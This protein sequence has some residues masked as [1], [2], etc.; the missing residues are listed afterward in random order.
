MRKKYDNETLEKVF[1]YYSL[2][3]NRMLTAAQAADCLNLSESSLF[4]VIA[5]FKKNISKQR[6]EELIQKLKEE[7]TMEAQ[8]D[9]ISE[10]LKAK[11]LCPVI[12]E[13]APKGGGKIEVEK[14]TKIQPALSLHCTFHA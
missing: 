3:E 4:R 9:V 13:N 14:D 6:E 11:F 12:L 1:Y 8:S 2:S 7:K 5:D 10:V